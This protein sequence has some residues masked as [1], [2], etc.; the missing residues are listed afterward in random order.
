M[1]IRGIMVCL[2]RFPPGIAAVSGIAVN[3]QQ[4]KICLDIYICNVDPD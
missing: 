1:V 3:V 4:Q 2:C